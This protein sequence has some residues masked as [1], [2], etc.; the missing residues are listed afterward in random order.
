MGKAAIIETVCK[1]DIEFFENNKAM[2]SN[3]SNIDQKSLI[4]LPGSSSDFRFLQ[5]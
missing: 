5:E 2:G 4:F 3:I 1:F